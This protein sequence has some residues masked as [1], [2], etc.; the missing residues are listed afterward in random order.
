MR[1]RYGFLIY[2]FIFLF[3]TEKYLINNN[4]IAQYVPQ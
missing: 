2:Q 1:I 3:Y 4:N